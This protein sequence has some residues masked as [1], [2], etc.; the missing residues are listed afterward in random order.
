MHAMYE[1]H[2]SASVLPPLS[3]QGLVQGLAL[4]QIVRLIFLTLF[5]T[6]LLLSTASPFVGFPSWQKADDN[7][8]LLTIS[9]LVDDRSLLNGPSSL[10]GRSFE[11]LN[12]SVVYLV[13]FE[14]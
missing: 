9:H 6:L 4:W 11:T 10:N 8:H 5:L 12:L 3:W 7:W 13:R 1:Q 2:T 14:F